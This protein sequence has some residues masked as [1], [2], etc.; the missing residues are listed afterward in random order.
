MP[1][2]NITRFFALLWK[3]YDYQ[4]LLV[5]A[6]FASLIVESTHASTWS[7]FTTIPEALLAVCLG[8]FIKKTYGLA[9][10]LYP[11]PQIPYS[12]CIGKPH[13]WFDNFARRQQ[14]ACLKAIG[15]DWK[16][17]QK[18][19]RIHRS[20]WVF[21]SSP[22]I[23]EPDD[24]VRVTRQLL[25]HFWELQKRVEGVPIYHF[26]FVAPPSIV[27]AFGA[28]V[29]RRVPH[30]AYQHVGNV[31][32]PYLVVVDTT[33]RD[34]SGGFDILNQRI[35]STSFEQVQIEKKVLEGRHQVIVA[36]DFTNHRTSAPYLDQGRAREFIRL[37]HRDGIGHFST[38]D[39][40]RLAREIA[41][42]LLEYSDSGVPMDI[43]INTPLALAFIIGW[44]LGPL[45]D[46]TL[47]EHNVYL[48]KLVRCFKLADPRLQSVDMKISSSI[49]TERAWSS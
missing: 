29:G 23:S 33:K 49:C 37:T 21:L 44:I 22:M 25:A 46:I 11:A 32:D 48:Q 3:E 47:C 38:T 1:K 24:W 6:T 28:L 26:F 14:E 12:V 7:I 35:P 39:W 17:V 8:Y 16:E 20:D 43:Y 31:R 40:E 19:F 15:V 45:S 13:D 10:S 36:L 27:F 42:A 30:V 34:T 2:G 5:L 4:L 18:I 41:S 9:R